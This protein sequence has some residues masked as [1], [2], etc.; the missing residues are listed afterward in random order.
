MTDSEL[1]CTN[2]LNDYFFKEFVYRDLYVYSGKQKQELCDGLVEFQD[3]YVI[4]QIKEKNKSTAQDW[5]QKK[6]YKKAVSQIKD[7]INMI[8]NANIIEV[9]S[10]TGEKIVLETQK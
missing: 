5:L 4:F 8:R 2:M 6:V 7:T 10:Y 3:A 9:E 1:Q